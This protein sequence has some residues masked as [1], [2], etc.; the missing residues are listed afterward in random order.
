M[1]SLHKILFICIKKNVSKSPHADMF[2][3]DANTPHSLHDLTIFL[4]VVHSG[5]IYQS[6]GCTILTWA[7]Q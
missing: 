1:V 4:A 7:D 3:R 2:L 5:Y 6:S